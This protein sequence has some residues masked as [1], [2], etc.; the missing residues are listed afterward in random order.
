[1]YF[2]LVASSA[3][4]FTFI[5]LVDLGLSLMYICQASLPKRLHQWS[6]FAV[7]YPIYHLS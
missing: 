1:M 6:L 7:I 3:H 5:D 4:F 2:G